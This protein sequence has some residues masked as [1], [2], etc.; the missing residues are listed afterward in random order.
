MKCLFFTVK[1]PPDFFLFSS[2][3]ISQLC[4]QPLAAFTL[5]QSGRP[6]HHLP[7]TPLPQSSMMP[8]VLPPAA[9]ALY[10]KVC[11]HRGQVVLLAQPQRVRQNQ[12]ETSCCRSY[13]FFC[14]EAAWVQ[15]FSFAAAATY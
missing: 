8:Q 12:Q 11:T 14:S 1:A 13:Y 7:I 5:K 6:R 9:Q 4:Q 15:N 2:P 3:Q 10:L